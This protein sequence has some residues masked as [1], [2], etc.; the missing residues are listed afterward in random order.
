MFQLNLYHMVNFFS[1]AC[2]A[3]THIYIF[4]LDP[5]VAPALQERQ[6]ELEK[7]ILQDTLEHKIKERPSPSALVEQGILT[8]K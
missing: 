2:F 4:I 5:K 3:L 1:L 7:S 8:G 6:H